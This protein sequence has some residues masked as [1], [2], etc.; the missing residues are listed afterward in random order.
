MGLFMGEDGGACEVLPGKD[1]PFH[2]AEGRMDGIV[3]TEDGTIGLRPLFGAPD[4]FAD[5]KHGQKEPDQD[6]GGSGEIQGEQHRGPP[7]VRDSGGRHGHELHRL[8]LDGLV[9][10]DDA[11]RQHQRGGGRPEEHRPVQP[12]EGVLLEQQT[13]AKPEGGQHQRGLPFI[14]KQFHHFPFSIWSIISFRSSSDSFSSSTKAD[15][16]A[17]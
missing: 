12:V 7:G 4:K 11:Q 2:P 8:H 5:T 6:D 16:I 1:D 9:H 10:R 13:P 3:D 14:D 15:T 17:R